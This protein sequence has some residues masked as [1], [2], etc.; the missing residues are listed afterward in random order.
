MCVVGIEG[1]IVELTLRLLP[2]MCCVSTQS[3][4]L[5]EALPDALTEALSSKIADSLAASL[6]AKIDECTLLHTPPSLS[7]YCIH[8]LGVL[9]YTVVEQ[10]I[11][12]ARGSNCM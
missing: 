12:N 8:I 11:T 2:C 1:L 10:L 5:L 3:P 9:L 6:S 7:S 4:A